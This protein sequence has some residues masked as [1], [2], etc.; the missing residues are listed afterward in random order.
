LL[1]ELGNKLQG[2]GIDSHKKIRKL[3]KP[4]GGFA[5]VAKS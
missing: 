2:E 5:S 1:Q 3:P 4:K